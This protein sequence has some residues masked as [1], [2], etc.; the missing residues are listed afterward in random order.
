M[1]FRKVLRS[2]MHNKYGRPSQYSMFSLIDE[3]DEDAGLSYYSILVDLLYNKVNLEF[4]CIYM[5]IYMYLYMYLFIYRCIFS[6]CW[7][8]AVYCL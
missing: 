1:F 4:I 5:L 6:Q 7:Q 2:V 3:N 8:S